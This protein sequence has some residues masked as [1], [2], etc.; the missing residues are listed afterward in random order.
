MSEI[1]DRDREREKRR[2]GKEKRER[3]TICR[4]SPTE[5]KDTHSHTQLFHTIADCNTV[6]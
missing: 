1:N 5:V 3:V 4:Q 2:D 6:N